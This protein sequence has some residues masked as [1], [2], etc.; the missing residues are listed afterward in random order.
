MYEWVW[1]I[2]GMILTGENWST[3][4]KPCHIDIA[5]ALK[6]DDL[7][8]KCSVLDQGLHCDKIQYMAINFSF[9][10]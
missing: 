3:G 8:L 2:G 6:T 7:R 1:T 4:R 9:Q 10:N 5:E